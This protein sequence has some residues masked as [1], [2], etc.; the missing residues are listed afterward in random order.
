MEF[1]F[2]FFC[3]N[4]SFK[5]CYGRTRWQMVRFQFFCINKSFKATNI[6]NPD[7]FITFQFFCINKS[8]KGELWIYWEYHWRRFQF[9][10][11]N[12]SFKALIGPRAMM[13]G[14][15]FNSF[16]S[17]SH[18][19]AMEELRVN[20]IEFQFFCINKS[21]K[22]VYLWCKTCS[23]Q[24]S[25]LLYQQVIQS[26]EWGKLILDL[27]KFQFFCINKS[28]KEQVGTHVVQFLSCFNSFVSTSHSKYVLQENDIITSIEFQFF[29]INKS[30][31]DWKTRNRD[32]S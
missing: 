28:F 15:S 9:F 2:Q 1:K 6:S 4:K 5:D 16:V 19:K 10:C 23:H 14:K 29:C 18:S 3:I 30:F 22:V 24:V 21:F 7:K 13:D 25:I 20:I 12:K 11:I 27:T 32:Q 31:K 8:F 17:T 26:N